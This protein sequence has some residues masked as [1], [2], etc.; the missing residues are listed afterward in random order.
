MADKLPISVFIIARNEADR[1]PHT[2]KSVI[3]WVSEVIVIDS[4]S[5]DDTVKVAEGLG[6]KVIFNEWKGYGPQKRFGETLCKH[7][8]LLNLDADE[9]ISPELAQEIQAIFAKPIF[10]KAAYSLRILALHRFQTTLPRIAAGTK[11]VRLYRKQEGSFRDSTVHDT[12]VLKDGVNV[13]VLKHPVVHRCFR[14][15]EHA[16][17]KINFYSSMQAEDL[18]KKGKNPS[19]LKLVTVPIIAFIKSYIFRKH[20]FYGM[21]GFIHS[22]IYAFGR[23]IRLAKAREKFQESAFHAQDVGER[24]KPIE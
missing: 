12:V 4:G 13:T 20:M 21:D 22:R 14:S 17:E 6:A 3:N 8:W 18:F 5:E 16:V 7:D 9:E 24:S 2:I 11:Q 23:Y 10:D 19:F 1:I 15:H